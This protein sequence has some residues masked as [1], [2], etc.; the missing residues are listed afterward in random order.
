MGEAA[1]PKMGIE[2]LL[3]S[4][5]VLISA[6]E[7]VTDESVTCKVTLFYRKI[8]SYTGS[9]SKQ[10]GQRP[11]VFFSDDGSLVHLNQMFRLNL[12]RTFEG[13]SHVFFVQLSGLQIHFSVIQV[14][15]ILGAVSKATGHVF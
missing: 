5:L 15:V 6:T 4:V 13:K 14:M 10:V 9:E 3:S 12:I 1:E 2:W 7:Y 8:A 11:S